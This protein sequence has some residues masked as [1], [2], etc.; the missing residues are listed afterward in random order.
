MNGAEVV[1]RFVS[2]RSDEVVRQTVVRELK[3]K[4]QKSVLK[5]NK[6][7]NISNVNLELNERFFRGW[8]LLGWSR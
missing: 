4:R 3:C 1:T 6:Q 2:T 7:T 5:P 8:D